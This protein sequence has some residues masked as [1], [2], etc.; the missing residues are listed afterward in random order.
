MTQ[1]LLVFPQVLCKANRHQDTS[2]R[3]ITII[4]RRAQLKRK[5]RGMDMG[6][7]CQCVP[8]DGKDKPWGK[9]EAEH[10]QHMAGGTQPGQP[11]S[12]F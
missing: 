7:Y 11:Y 8:G 3:P 4:Q 2:L 12:C 9:E 5:T 1:W 6:T 10:L